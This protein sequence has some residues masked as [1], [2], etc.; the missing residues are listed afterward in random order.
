MFQ[1]TVLGPSLWNAFFA[2]VAKAARSE[3]GSEAM[4]ADDLDVSHDSK[5]FIVNTEIFET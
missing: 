4:F 2:D 1:G 5:R 3:G